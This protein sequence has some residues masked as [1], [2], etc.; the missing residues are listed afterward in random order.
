MC[1]VAP[2]CAT[3]AAGSN[4]EASLCFFHQASSGAAAGGLVAPSGFFA[5]CS[6]PSLAAAPPAPPLLLSLRGDTIPKTLGTTVLRN[7]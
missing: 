2:W 3:K 7:H 5:S 4:T 6:A 1:A